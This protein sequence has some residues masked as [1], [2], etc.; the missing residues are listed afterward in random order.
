MVLIFIVVR[1]RMG[2]EERREGERDRERRE[3]TST[4]KSVDDGSSSM[5]PVKRPP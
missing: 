2:A 4:S 5:R 3:S 1:K